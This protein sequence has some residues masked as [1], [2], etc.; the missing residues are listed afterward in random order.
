MEKERLMKGI[1]VGIITLFMSLA[2]LPAL[3]TGDSF[4]KGETNRELGIT[5]TM[6]AP[7][8]AWDCNTI[9]IEL[10]EYRSDG[11][12]ETRIVRL[13]L[14]AVREILK[15]FQNT[16]DSM[17]TFRI[18]KKHGLIPRD[19]LLEDW[20][21]GMYERIKTLGILPGD[22][23]DFL[24]LNREAARL[25]LPFMISVLNKV[26]AVSI[27]GSGIRVGVPSYRGLLK[28]MTGFRFM[29]LFDI[30]GGLVGIISTKNVIRQHSFV[31][32]PGI[33]G[34]IGFVGMHLRIPFILDIHTGFSALT[35]A[36]GLG[37]H[38]VDVLPWLSNPDME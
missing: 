8:G 30:R 24:R 22:I 34:M 4:I 26:D 29:D 32:I 28:L 2:A 7:Y 19:T 11:T 37:I 1:S 13:S 23:Q 33:M 16:Q 38:T 17:E 31:T 25:K 21:R 3:G 12:C 14:D 20:R 27:I 15:A 18:L 9:E 35:F 10:T 36:G 5:K 6:N